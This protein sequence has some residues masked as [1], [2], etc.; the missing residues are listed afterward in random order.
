MTSSK[1]GSEYLVLCSLLLSLG[2]NDSEHLLSEDVSAFLGTDSLTGKLDSLL[3]SL[4]LSSSN[5]FQHL[6]LEWRESS[7]LS[8]NLTNVLHTLDTSSLAE[9]E[10]LFELVWVSLGLGH[11]VTLVHSHKYSSF[12]HLIS[13]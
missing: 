7:D 2:L 8:D 1:H 11:D 10:V 4:G 12:R 9:G 13:K 5:H 6:L 3:L